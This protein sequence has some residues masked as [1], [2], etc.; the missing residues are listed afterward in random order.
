MKRCIIIVLI[1]A[2]SMTSVLATEL[3]PIGGTRSDK[4][5]SPQISLQGLNFAAL[6]VT[7]NAKEYR[8]TLWDDILQASLKGKMY[9]AGATFDPLKG[10]D[11][12]SVNA[13]WDISGGNIQALTL[14]FNSPDY[15]GTFIIRPPLALLGDLPITG[16]ITGT[17]NLAGASLV[18]RLYEQRNVAT[19]QE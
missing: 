13:T 3:I 18:Y 11:T 10:K 6:M 9:E 12:L 15:S 16:K 14:I 2:L 19:K 8:N 1:C 7:G 4:G 5:Q 17:S